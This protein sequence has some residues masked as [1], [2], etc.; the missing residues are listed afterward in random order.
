MS[1]IEIQHPHTIKIIGLIVAATLLIV[2]GVWLGYYLGGNDVRATMPQPLPPP[3]TEIPAPLTEIPGEDM[4]TTD[5]TTPT[6]TTPAPGVIAIDTHIQLPSDLGSHITWTDRSEI[7]PGLGWLGTSPA[8]YSG[9]GIYDNEAGSHYYQIG[10]IKNGN[11]TGRVILLQAAP[12]GMGE[13]PWYRFVEYDNKIVM[14]GNYSGYA[15]QTFDPQQGTGSDDKIWSTRL[16]KQLAVDNTLKIPALDFPLTLVGPEPNQIIKRQGVYDIDGSAS[17]DPTPNDQLVFTDPNYGPVKVIANS[18]AFYI[19][20]PG[21]FVVRYAFEPVP[22]VLNEKGVPDITWPDRVRR[23]AD[24]SY[25]DVG[26]CGSINYLAVVSP[27][28]VDVAKDLN[29]INKTPT[30]F[31]IYEL[32]NTNHPLLKNAYDNSY[33]IQDGEQKIPYAQF[34]AAK[35]VLFFIDPFSRLIKLQN[36]KFQLAAECGKPVIYLYPEKTTQ[37]HVEV[38]PAGGLSFS[39]PAYGTGW[40]VI[41]GPHSNLIETKSGQTYPYLFWEGRGGLYETPERGFVVAQADVESTLREKLA[42]LGLNTK[43]TNDFLEFWLPRMQ[44]KPYY[45]ITFLGTSQMNV[46]APLSITPRP[47]TIF[48]I[49]MDFTPLD[50]PITVEPLRLGRTP[51]RKG[52]T[53][54]EWGGVLR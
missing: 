2:G 32:K 6:T 28:E 48:R 53:V 13:S 15:Y 10:T 34:L 14:L 12:E 1:P 26:G 17:S 44:A 42:T 50:T 5:T 23:T 45:F 52:F 18:G 8:Q 40:D 47:D 30:G 16:A 20:T 49:L 27:K 54:V 37:V 43:E 25:T 3:L 4:P 11:K 46:L 33:W 31:T 38:K 41:A 9:G 21:G 22:L 29:A 39:E 51:E 35:P 24:Y 36:K 19:D 7:K